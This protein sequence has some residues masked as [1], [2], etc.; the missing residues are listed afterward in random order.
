[1]HYL[2]I[3]KEIAYHAEAT[4]LIIPDNARKR[5]AIKSCELFVTLKINKMGSIILI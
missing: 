2:Y 3:C 5:N 4:C 1:M